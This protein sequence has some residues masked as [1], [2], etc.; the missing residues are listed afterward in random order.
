MVNGKHNIIIYY[1][2]DYYLSLNY[3]ADW[4]L[5]EYIIEAQFMNVS[6]IPG[7]QFT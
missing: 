7:L 4:K 1:L 5:I 2:I 3:F 6:K